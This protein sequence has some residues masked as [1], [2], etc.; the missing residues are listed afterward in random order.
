MSVAQAGVVHRVEN[1]ET[2]AIAKVVIGDV[3]LERTR[4]EVRLAN[5]L[6]L[7]VG[8]SDVVVVRLQLR[9][10]IN[11][12]VVLSCMQSMVRKGIDYCG[13]MVAY[14]AGVRE[15]AGEAKGRKGVD[16]TTYTDLR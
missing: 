8:V 2:V 1:E 15:I 5:S 9:E 6:L 12:Y 3:M 13:W 11:L 4:K 10:G 16:D 7:S 14:L